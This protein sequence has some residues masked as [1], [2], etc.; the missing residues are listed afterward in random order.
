[1]SAFE[2][3]VRAPDWRT[4]AGC[5][6]VGR[7][8]CWGMDAR[9][10]D[11]SGARH[12]ITALLVELREGRRDAMDR[13]VPLV[14]HALRRIAHG[15]L[16]VERTGH[17]LDT[18]AL[19]HEAYLRLVDLDRIEWRDRAHFFTVAAGAMRRILIEYARGYR[20]AKRGGGLR[21]LPLDGGV[22]A[23]EERADTLVA[24]DEALTRLTALDERQARVVECRF[25]AGLTEEETAE[26]LGVTAR[27]VA[28]DWVKARGWLYQELGR[29]DP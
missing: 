10:V 17:T 3:V 6:P 4:I 7:P 2:S 11:P 25:F 28:R 26:A 24:L 16:S 1:V 13:L 20:A 9:P 12:E 15:Q 19:V 23:M 18:T 8:Y 29:D 21:T 14:Y 27:T 22:I 5:H